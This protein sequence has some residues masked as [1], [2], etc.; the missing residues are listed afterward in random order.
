MMKLKLKKWAKELFEGEI[1]IRKTE[2]WLVGAVCLLAGIV[3]GLLAA[4]MTHGIMI[5][6]NNGSNNSD[7]FGGDGNVNAA[8]GDMKEA[9]EEEE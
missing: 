9:G 3:H 4:P 1:T 5:G 6:S 8:G 2:L 7:N